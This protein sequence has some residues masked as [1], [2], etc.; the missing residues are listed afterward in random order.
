MS[1]RASVREKINILFVLDPD[2][3]AFIMDYFDDVWRSL[4]RGMSRTEKLN[5]LLNMNDPVKIDSLLSSLTMQAATASLAPSDAPVSESVPLRREISR[6]QHVIRNL[7]QQLSN[8]EPKPSIGSRNGLER[9]SKHTKGFDELFEKQH[10]SQI[11]VN[12]HLW[13][14]LAYS[15]LDTLESSLGKF[16][17]ISCEFRMLFAYERQPC[18]QIYRSL[19]TAASDILTQQVEENDRASKSWSQTLSSLNSGRRGGG[20]S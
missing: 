10:S 8:P 3:D 5:Q 9:I 14:T 6:L 11:E 15:I 13:L 2:L 19:L 1:T 4:S 12:E 17:A 7:E 16:H 20:F 18:S